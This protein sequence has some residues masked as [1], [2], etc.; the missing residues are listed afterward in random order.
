[1]KTDQF[2]G[3]RARMG[4]GPRTLACAAGAAISLGMAA[5]QASAQFVWT[6]DT[7]GSFNDPA[8]WQGGL[9]PSNLN[10]PTTTLSFTSGNVAAITAS[11][12]LGTPMMVNSISFANASPFTLAGS[13]TTNAFQMTGTAPSFI[14]S[15]LGASTIS[16]PIQ[17]AADTTFG[18]TGIGDLTLSGA[19]SGIGRLTLPALP[20]GL[21][22]TVA[23]QVLHTVVLGSGTGTYGGL[24]LDGG[25]MRT[26]GFGPTTFGPAGGTFTVT[27]NG[28][29]IQ[30]VANLSNGVGVSTFQLDGTLRIIGGGS[31]FNLTTTQL[32]G[33]GSLVVNGTSNTGFTVSSNSSGYSGA[34]TIDKSDLPQFNAGAGG[35]VIGG[36]NGALL[37]VPSV[38]IRS[39]GTLTLQ[40]STSAN[41]N[42]NRL[43][44]TVPINLRSGNL[45]LGAST[46]GL[47]E[48]VGAITG[49]GYSTI[50]S[51]PGSAGTATLAAASLARSDRGTFLFRG[52][53]L[54]G[55][56]AVRGN[57]TF[58]SAP[59]ADLIGGGAAAGATNISILPYAIGDITASGAGST[60]VTYDASG[61]RPLSTATEYAADLAS[62][63][64]T[65]ARLTAATANA[66]NTVNALAIAA[67][68]SVTGA[69]TLNITSGA[70]LNTSTTG[71]IGLDNTVAFG[72][73]EGHIFSSGST[74]V[75]TVDGRLTGSG[76]LTKSGPGQLTLTNDNSGLTG[77][78]TLNAGYINFNSGSALPGTGQI[79]SSGTGGGATANAAG[80]I[81]SGDSPLDLSRDIVVNA[82]FLNAKCAAAGQSLTLSGQVTGAGGLFI[83]T[84]VGSDV[85]L[86]NPN[87]SYAGVTFINGGSVH[88]PS[89]AVLGN[90]GAVD[91][92]ATLV[93]EGDWTTSRMVNFNGGATSAMTLNTNGHNAT[94]SGPVTCYTTALTSQTA[95]TLKKEGPGTLAIT[96]NANTFVQSIAVNGGTL[97]IDGT[98]PPSLANAVTVNTDATLDGTG[99]IFRNI[100]IAPGGTLAPGHS[101][102]ALTQFG[103]LAL[104]AGSNFSV[105]LNGSAPGGYD[106]MIVNGTVSLTDANLS[107]SLGYAPS[108]FDVFFILTNDGADPT[109]GTLAGLP[110]GATVSLGSFGG[111]AY[112]AQISYLGDAATGALA[113]GNDVVLFNAIPAPGTAGLLALGGIFITRRRRA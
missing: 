22:G 25:N 8:K 98:L 88:I 17:L 60:F 24:T 5:G 59:S 92:T 20:A 108:F 77:P 71:S 74:A 54:G 64:D 101:A 99:L 36:A 4:F 50:T 94:L 10:D 110:E 76:G 81:Y 61:V 42:S 100:N 40:N 58:A 51:S 78:L 19:I 97:R 21:Q 34:I 11:Q 9:A 63:A 29:V 1:M 65:N 7:S 32:N 14:L 44:D 67:G 48:T 3:N 66:G 27:S 35:M 38:D 103:N 53:A 73:A 91:M 95:G 109:T 49:A 79:N 93:L 62:G 70:I 85:Y 31:N 6:G 45:S 106:Q 39:G 37:N 33:S 68:G 89:D 26:A 102:G 23:S 13:P 107:I 28:G 105:E 96:G 2:V 86:T 55:A 69:G 87:N 30:S 57:I 12:N 41:S 80:L 111:D 75:L 52:T 16:A 15:A 113:G 43:G 104:A 90:G 83:E 112:T 47:T 56:A 72:A 18:G 46:V 82:G 84:P